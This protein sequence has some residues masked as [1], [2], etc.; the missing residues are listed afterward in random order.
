[1]SQLVN[2]NVTAV[3]FVQR[4]ANRKKFFLTKSAGEQEAVKKDKGEV[5]IMHEVIRK[6]LQTLMKSA[7]HKDSSTAKVVEALKKVE[8]IKKLELA[9]EDFVEVEKDI[10]LIKTLSG[11]D[12]TPAADPDAD[13]D[14]DPNADGNPNSDVNKSDKETIAD[15]Q[16]SVTDLTKTLKAQTEA[17]RLSDIKKSLEDRA[18]HAAIDVEKEAKLILKLEKIDKDAAESMIERFEQASK[19][20]A[21]SSLYEETGSSAEGDESVMAEV[22]SDVT[23]VVEELEKT[24]KGDTPERQVKSITQLMKK[25]GAG[26]YDQ[27][28]REHRQRARLS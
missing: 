24:E 22:V 9:D 17:G 23:K 18:P 20:L 27:Y 26:F 8:V 21:S 14:A 11:S 2:L 16:K 1:M 4:G 28:V 5:K 7:E 10:E 19:I 12:P 15:L 6:E 25:K 13:P 3:A